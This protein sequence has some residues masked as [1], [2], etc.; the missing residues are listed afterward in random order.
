[1]N[2]WKEKGSLPIFHYG[3]AR[4]MP[5]GYRLIEDAAQYEPL[6]DFS[7]PAL[8]FHGTADQSV[9]IEYSA[10]FVQNH[11]NA[12][13]I[14]MQ[15]GHELTDVLDQIWEQASTFLLGREEKNEC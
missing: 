4:D 15:S 10:E 14:R 3:E 12:C 2:S 11:P 8:L 9:P 7:Q 13:L 1:L 6:P 5:I